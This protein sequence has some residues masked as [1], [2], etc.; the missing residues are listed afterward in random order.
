MNVPLNRWSAPS[1]VELSVVMLPTIVVCERLIVLKLAMADP[2]YDVLPAIVE[3]VTVAVP[4]LSRPPP[5][6]LAVLAEIVVSTMVR[7]PSLNTPAP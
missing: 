2:Q 1:E 5:L 3:L 4:S 7:L 6:T